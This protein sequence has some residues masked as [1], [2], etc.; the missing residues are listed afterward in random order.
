[1]DLEKWITN[2]FRIEIHNNPPGVHILFD[3]YHS[4]FI[5]DINHNILNLMIYLKLNDELWMNRYIVNVRIINNDLI[6]EKHRQYFNFWVILCLKIVFIICQNTF[7]T[8]TFWNFI[9]LLIFISLMSK[10][11]EMVLN[12]CSFKMFNF[13][14][15][16]SFKN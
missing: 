3:S 15:L 5:L 7:Q 8:Q 6:R 13:G 16:S 12:F 9:E 2:F 14:F 4:D 11:Y 10:F 1:M